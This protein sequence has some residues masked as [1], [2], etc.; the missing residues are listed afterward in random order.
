M[1]IGDIQ[2]SDG[3]AFYFV[4]ICWLV[5]YTDRRQ[6]A[7]TSLEHQSALCV[8][9]NTSCVYVTPVAIY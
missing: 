7:G 8:Y 6:N 3:E 2:G 5:C 1:I 9:W 4:H